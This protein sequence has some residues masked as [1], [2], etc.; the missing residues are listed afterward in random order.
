MKLR[1]AKNAILDSANVLH[2]LSCQVG[3][4]APAV[5]DKGERQCRKCGR[6]FELAPEM[7]YR[8]CCHV[9]T[10]D[11]PPTVLPYTTEALNG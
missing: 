1:P 4:K 10:V 7:I 2:C 9:P 3:T 8:V 5:G 11:V 6:W